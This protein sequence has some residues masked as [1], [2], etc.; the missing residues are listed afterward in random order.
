MTP[1]KRR[2]KI[3]QLIRN[4]PSVTNAGISDVL[5]ISAETVRS[6]LIYLEGEGILKRH[7]GFSEILREDAAREILITTGALTKDERREELSR[8]IAEK[9]E[10]RVS[11]LAQ[12]FAVS[13]GTI[14][15]DLQALEQKGVIRRDHGRARFL[16]CRD[17]NLLVS[18]LTGNRQDRAVN[19]VCVR[20]L[21]N[22]E[23]G[24]VVYL[25]GSKYG[26]AL[27]S[28]LEPD[29][30][31]T[32]VTNSLKVALILSGRG[33]DSSVFLLPGMV[34]DGSAD[35]RFWDSVRDRLYLS[36]AFVS[37]QSFSARQ[38]FLFEDQAHFDAF[39]AIASWAEKVFVLVDSAGLSRGGVYGYAIK[40]ALDSLQEVAVDDG[41]SPEGAAQVF[42]DWLP[43][44]I[45]GDGYALKSPFRKRY[46]IGFSALYGSHEFSQT[47]RKSIEEAAKKHADVELLLTD[48]KMDPETTLHNIETFIEKKVDLVIEY[49]HQFS[50][51]PLIVEKLSNHD[52]P[53]IAID[54]PVP[55]AVYFGANNYRAG[56]IAGAEAA[57]EVEQRWGGAVDYVI[58]L[59]D[60]A[61][62]PIAENR[63]RGMLESIRTRIRFDESRL[64]QIDTGNDAERTE[65]EV[66]AILDGRKP[67][68]RM[69][70]LAFND[71][72]CLAAAK[73]IRAHGCT[74]DC[75]AV[76]HS[77][78]RS[79]SKEIRSPNS[80]VVGSV[81][82]FPEH[83]GEKIIDLA[84]KILKKEPVS[85]SN[86][87]EHRWMTT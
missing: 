68:D 4:N 31:I 84:L 33:F 78:I 67:G 30:E 76:S 58:A 43:V 26:I 55:G 25:D 2:G 75:V 56:L 42:P 65:R 19:N 50:L 63:V 22:L 13:E 40:D 83:Y 86:Y 17:E 23:D 8:I 3:V 5:A 82:F 73:A 28:M 60:T 64:I 77:H 11:A 10:A 72:V 49:Q 59:S 34:K 45:C 85:P 14:R 80:P 1:E 81:A 41:I 54:I 74:E 7:H 57:R 39:R 51:G 24:G 69:L 32:V 38:G 36:K 37:A 79:I 15:S 27:A 21:E 66:S 53:I 44:V 9:G 70:I 47:V 62:G 6:D 29:G 16:Q 35:L 71:V 20:A 52:I 12:M 46:V 18:I 87:T 61:T 48:N